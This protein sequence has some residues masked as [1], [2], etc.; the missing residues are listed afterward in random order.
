MN[1]WKDTNKQEPSNRINEDAGAASDRV[2]S[3]VEDAEGHW[4]EEDEPVSLHGEIN[5]VDTLITGQHFGEG[6]GIVRSGDSWQEEFAEDDMFD[7]YRMEDAVLG[8]GLHKTIADS[9]QEFG[10]ELSPAQGGAAPLVPMKPEWEEQ[11]GVDREFRGMEEKVS[12]RQSAARGDTAGWISL[13]L[14][15]ASLFFWP[16]LLGPAAVIA[17]AASFFAGSRA[18]GAW[19]VGLGLLSLVG[20]FFW[21]PYIS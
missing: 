6:A 2:G 1:D 15:V 8:N 5:S 10:G 3:T 21:V 18:L 13:L 11:G 19:A 16:A 12:Q 14:A 4:N 20:Y 9:Y 7:P 17:G